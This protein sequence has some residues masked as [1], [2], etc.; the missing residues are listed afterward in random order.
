MSLM[1]LDELRKQFSKQKLNNNKINEKINLRNS[2][3]DSPE[4]SS[5][6]SENQNTSSAA[7][8]ILRDIQSKNCQIISSKVNGIRAFK[9]FFRKTL[10]QSLTLIFLVCFFSTFF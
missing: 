10:F 2:Y 9:I 4:S 3:I 1:N 8:S 5:S 7:Q 6:E